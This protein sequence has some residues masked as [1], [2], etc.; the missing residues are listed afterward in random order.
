MKKSLGVLSSFISLVRPKQWLKNALLFF[1]PFFA[2][3]IGDP[4]VKS[5]L[6][7]AFFSFAL[8]SSCSYIL[9]DIRDRETDKNHHIKR[10]RPLASGKVSV[11]QASFL[12]GV[13]YFASIL[14]GSAVSEK[15]EA[16]LIIYLVISFLYSFFLKQMALIDIFVVSFGFMIRVI[17][18]GVAFHVEVSKWLFL[19]VFLVSLLLASGKRLGELIDLGE[20]AATHRKSLVNYSQGFLGGLLWFS[21]AASLITYALYTLERTTTLFYTVPLVAFGIIRYNYLAMKGTGEPTDVLVR[22]MPIMVT[23]LLWVASIGIL[24]Y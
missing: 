10:K 14:I 16:L 23:G 3:K 5:A 18:G 12:A 1:P 2:V 4:A 8:M 20:G 24:I 9:N 11:L 17:A 19:T 15:F 13:V 6:V 7:P 22:D 21:A